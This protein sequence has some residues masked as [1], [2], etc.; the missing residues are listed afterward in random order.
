MLY[1]VLKT[2]VINLYFVLLFSPGASFD[3]SISSDTA[4]VYP[5]ETVKMDCIISASGTS[6]TGMRFVFF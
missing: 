1:Y 4:S 5:W 2:P 3:L 6:N